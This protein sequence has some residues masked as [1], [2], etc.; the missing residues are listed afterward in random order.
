M[1]S[2]SHECPLLSLFRRLL[3][4]CRVNAHAARLNGGDRDAFR[5]GSEP[6]FD[7]PFASFNEHSL[8]LSCRAGLPVGVIAKLEKIITP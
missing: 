3:D 1:S 4:L 6:E 5:Y 8:F 7:L 2:Y